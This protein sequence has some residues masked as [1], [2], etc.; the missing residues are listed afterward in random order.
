MSPFYMNASQ[1]GRP[2][3]LKNLTTVDSAAAASYFIAFQAF[4]SRRAAFG[5]K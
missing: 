1:M 5:T 2:Q 3:E 4:E